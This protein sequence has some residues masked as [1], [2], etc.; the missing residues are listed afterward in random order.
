[1]YVRLDDPG[2]PRKTIHSAICERTLI[3]M[4][5]PV[6]LQPVLVRPWLLMARWAD[7]VSVRR[8]RA[9]TEICVRTHVTDDEG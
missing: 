8:E 7:A 4:L 5:V 6:A 9:L 2:T 1:M 3:R